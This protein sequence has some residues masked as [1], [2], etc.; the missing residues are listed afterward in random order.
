[1]I[2]YGYQ[3]AGQ[4]GL[5]FACVVSGFRAGTLDPRIRKP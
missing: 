4:Y 1:M 2:Y 3:N 5:G